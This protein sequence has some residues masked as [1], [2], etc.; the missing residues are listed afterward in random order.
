LNDFKGYS[1]YIGVD[2]AATSDLTAVSYLIIKDDIY[3]FK[4]HYYLPE[5]ALTDK[6]D[7]ELYKY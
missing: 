5:S 6:A 1:C 3:Y 4:I 7:K 2:L